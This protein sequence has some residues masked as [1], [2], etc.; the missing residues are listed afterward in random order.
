[1][2]KSQALLILNGSF[3]AQKIIKALKHK[4]ANKK[5]TIG[6]AAILI[7][8]NSAS[9]VYIN[10]K[11]KR[12]KEIGVNFKKYLLPAPKGVSEKI[13]LEL[14]KKLNQDRSVHGILVQLPLPK[15]FNAQ[16]IIQE[17]D[18][19]KDVDGFV[20][21]KIIPPTIQ[22]I[23]HL[24]KLSKIKLKNK[25]AVILA[26]S[27][28]FAEPLVEEL[29]NKK[30][31]TQILLKSKIR[32]KKLEIRNYD[33]I[34]IAFGKKHWLKSN[35]IKKDSIIIDVGINKIKNSKKIFGDVH[36]DCFKK[37][38]YISPVPGGVGPLTVA[39]L[40]KNLFTLASHQ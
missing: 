15:K 29:K 16:K 8:N 33:I 27:P 12:A 19:N 38:K 40:F 10:I 30:I 20:S 31:K 17:I 1:M 3:E 35:M 26:N 2:K 28:E 18:I 25:K 23:L 32:N 11:E 21:K 7:G 5:S 6:L 4:I 9:Q 36:P 22:A 34:I 24:I 37:S 13:I 14:I 39:F